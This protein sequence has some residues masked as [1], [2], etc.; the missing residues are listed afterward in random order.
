MNN[1]LTR[2]LLT[3]ILSGAICLTLF[4]GS[5][6]AED[7]VHFALV[8]PKVAANEYWTNILLTTAPHNNTTDVV[9][10]TGSGDTLLEAWADA[11]NNSGYTYGIGGNSSY[12]YQLS[13]INGPFTNYEGWG[14]NDS[15]GGYVWW[16]TYV[17][18]G[19]NLSTWNISY[20]QTGIDLKDH[21]AS[22][23]PYFAFVWGTW[24]TWPNPWGMGTNFTVL[25]R[26]Y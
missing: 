4:A 11:A 22:E 10:I 16:K 19:G 26:D 15:E 2:I 21:S 7:E 14:N 13:S 8:D 3:L 17:S 23:F 18:D 9:W 25:P 6:A 5:V 20:S 12:P 1:K 24:C